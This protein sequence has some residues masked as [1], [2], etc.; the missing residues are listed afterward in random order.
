VGKGVAL[1]VVSFNTVSTVIKSFFTF[2]PD[3]DS[4]RENFLIPLLKS[5]KKVSV[6]DELKRKHEEKV[7]LTHVQSAYSTLFVVSLDSVVKIQKMAPEAFENLNGVAIGSALAY[8]GQ[9]SVGDAI[10][11]KDQPAWFTEVIAPIIREL[12]VLSIDLVLNGSGTPMQERIQ[13]FS[14]MQTQVK[15]AIVRLCKDSK[16]ANQNQCLNALK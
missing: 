13:R 9:E 14:R 12:G 10:I 2:E 6:L 11:S 15:N 7:Y 8:L 3:I 1:D 5:L 16:T 4:I